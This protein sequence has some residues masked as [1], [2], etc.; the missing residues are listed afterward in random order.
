M[1]LNN[2]LQD[3][4]TLQLQLFIFMTTLN[5]HQRV[6]S[7]QKVFAGRFVY[8]HHSKAKNVYLLILQKI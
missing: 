3:M 2:A 5:I 4:A 7:C 1:G 6:V 8:F